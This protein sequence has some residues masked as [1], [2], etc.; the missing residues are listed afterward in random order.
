M[1]PQSAI[2]LLQDSTFLFV[3]C[4]FSFHLRKD[5]FVVE[6]TVEVVLQQVQWSACVGE[7]LTVC[8]SFFVCDG[9]CGH[10]K[11]TGIY[12]LWSSHFELH[13]EKFP[14]DQSLPGS[15]KCRNS[16]CPGVWNVLILALILS[17]PLYVHLQSAEY[18]LCWRQQQIEALR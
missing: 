1:S 14:Q 11:V 10:Q 15:W 9:C 12:F 8:D 4:F 5:T 6:S 18:H 17:S 7:L 13:R 3:S 2:A 16:F